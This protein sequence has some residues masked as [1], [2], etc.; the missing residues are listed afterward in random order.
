MDWKKITDESPFINARDREVIKLLDKA[1]YV[2][3]A[4]GVA[5]PEVKETV[6]WPFSH[7][8]SIFGEPGKTPKGSDKSCEIDRWPAIWRITE[9]LKIGAGAGNSHQHQLVSGHGLT[10]S[11]YKK[12][13]GEWYYKIDSSVIKK[14]AEKF[15][16]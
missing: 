5:D 13:D 16:I 9:K 2:V 15:G 1:G 4:V 12:I 7:D 3:I 11:T 8:N 14:A 10:K 6:G